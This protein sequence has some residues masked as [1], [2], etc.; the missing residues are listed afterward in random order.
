MRRYLSALLLSSTALITAPALAQS[1]T[2]TQP[3][4]PSVLEQQ[5]QLTRDLSIIR[6]RVDRLDLELKEAELKKKLKALREGGDPFMPLAP[7]APTSGVQAPAFR[8]MA[9][10]ATA[11]QTSPVV[12]SLRGR[13]GEYRATIQLGNGT[14]VNAVK[15]QV[16]PGGLHVLSVSADG[17]RVSPKPDGKDAYNLPFASPSTGNAIIPVTSARLPAPF[18]P[19]ALPAIPTINIEPPPA[20]ANKPAGAQPARNAPIPLR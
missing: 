13:E 11:P 3:N 19:P 5:E 17:V 10:T 16:L 18:A 6:A 14:Y 8:P 20:A 15:G 7:P 4:A 12:D 1:P 2:E 9:P